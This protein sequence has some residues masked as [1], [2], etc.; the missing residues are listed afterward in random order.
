MPLEAF[1]FYSKDGGEPVKDFKL[2][3]E[4]TRLV[5]GRSLDS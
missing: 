2:G 5:L 4:L 1:E 3:S